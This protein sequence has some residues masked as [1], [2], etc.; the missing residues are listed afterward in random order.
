MQHDLIAGLKERFSI[1]EEQ[2]EAAK[3]ISLSAISA[4]KQP[5]E[6][7]QLIMIGGQLG[8]KKEVLTDSALQE[9]NENAVLTS[10]DDLRKYH[11]NIESIKSE[12]P[13]MVQ[14]LTTDFAR[15]LL[16]H[17]ENIAIQEKWNVMMEATLSNIDSV[18]AKINKFKGNNYE[19]SLSILSLNKMFSYLNTEEEYEKTLLVEKDG[20]LVS[21]QHHDQHYEEIAQTIQKLEPKNLLDKVNIYKYELQ[22]NDGKIEAKPIIL[23]QNKLDF[24]DT[25]L[26]ERNRDF[27]DIELIYLKDKAQL[28]KAMKANRDAYFLEKIRFDLN[29]KSLVEDKVAKIKIPKLKAP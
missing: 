23:G 22:E 1:S 13:D 20:K 24:V 16:T 29:V 27:T 28:I 11:P 6:N 17:L 15:T 7:P 5:V 10:L 12:Y 8:S 25:Y 26:R 2:M 18:V 4:G 19:I 14:P 3:N 9:L 21:K